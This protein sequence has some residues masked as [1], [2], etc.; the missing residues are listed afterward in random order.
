MIQGGRGGAR[1]D[2][3]LGAGNVLDGGDGDDTL[4]GGAQADTAFGGA[5]KDTILGMGGDDELFGQAD[6]DALD[7]GDGDDLLVVGAGG[8]SQGQTAIGGFGDD[9]IVVRDV[10]LGGEFAVAPTGQSADTYR[11]DGGMDTLV[12]DT[13][14]LLAADD[15]LLVSLSNAQ[16]N[17]YGV[18]TA[19]GIEVGIFAGGAGDNVFSAEVFTGRVVMRGNGG[20]DT[21]TGGD[22]DDLLD[23]GIDVDNQLAGGK[24]DD[25]FLVGVGSTTRI[26][27]FPNAG[28]DT[29]DLAPLG[30]AG[31][32]VRVGNAAEGVT[33]TSTTP[34]VTV[35][36]FND[37][38]DHVLL[39]NGTNSLTLRN[40]MTTTARFVAGGGSDSIRY[41]DTVG[42]WGAW[43]AGVTVDLAAGTATG[44]AGA[45]GFDHV[46]GGE[47]NDELS[48]NNDANR[49]DGRGGNDTLT[50]RRGDDTLFGGSGDDSLF[51]DADNDTL[52]GEGGMNELAG[53]TGDDA[54]EFLDFGQT[55]TVDEDFD[56]GTDRM[57]FSTGETRILFDVGGQIVA[58]FGTSRVTALSAAGIDLVR[59]GPAA[60][61]FRIADGAAFAGRLEGGGTTGDGFKYLDTLDYSLW[62]SPVSVDYSVVAAVGAPRAVTGVAGVVD[63]RHVIGGSRSDTLTGGADP[64]WFEGR[65]G[66]D[67]L[68]GSSLADKLEGDAGGDTIRGA[69][70]NDL[71]RGGVGNDTLE[72]GAD[73]DTF[74]FADAFGTDSVL[75]GPDGGSDVM[76]FSAVSV[77]LAVAIGS[78]TATT[79]AGDRAT[80]AGDAIERVVGGA[81]GD[82]FVITGPDVV[83]AGTLDGGAGVNELAY[84][85]PTRE[86]A[87][88][89]AAGDRPNVGGALRFATVTADS[90]LFAPVF[91][92][93]FTG[94]VNENAPLD[95]IVFTAAA[96]DA[97]DPPGNVITYALVAGLG[98][99]ADLVT[100]EPTSGKVR[101]KAPANFETQNAYFFRV[102]ATDAGVP[103][104]SATLDVRVNVL[105]VAEPATPPRIAAPA[106]FFFTEDTPGPLRFT[107]TPFSDADSPAATLMTVT[108][109]I[110]DGAIAAAN[111]GGVVV[112][113]PPTART[114]TGTLANLNAFFTADPARITYAP[115]AD[116]SG[117][118]VLGVTIAEGPVTQRLSSAV[119]VPVTIAAV[120]D[121]PTVR[122][123]LGFVVQED[124]PGNLRWPAGLPVVTD[125]DSPVVSVRLSVDAGQIVAANGL[126]V[127]V[128]GTPAAR[129]FTGT[130]AAV[131]A[132]FAALGRI[133]YAPAANDFGDRTLRIEAGDGVAAAA[134][135]RTIRVTPVNDAP[136]IAALAA[137]ADGRRNT[138]FEITHDMLLARSG[139]RDIDTAALAFRVESVV[140][141]SLQRWNGA[142]W[143]N[144]VV[145]N[146]TPAAQRLIGPGQR[147]RWVPP[148]GAVGAIA[149]FTIRAW[150]GQAASAVQ[151]RVTVN[152]L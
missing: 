65:D 19:L 66:G 10:T 151:S 114:F 79:A 8:G 111:G 48:G 83:F 122:A 12:L 102:L 21:L 52:R 15:L 69:A 24:G 92:S 56:Q 44:T 75:E 23:A 106:A 137:F 6:A 18:D 109:R 103:S 127:V 9:T 36:F 112:G 11:G 91:N 55:D 16:L 140:R 33:A 147:I 93:G 78:V 14:P 67:T 4:T 132:Y 101:L 64:V 86:I 148:A 142:R 1:S 43:A 115:A 81:A 34:G 25:R 104:R 54:Y 98:D 117:P 141:G 13:S 96:T 120:N 87:A 39:G 105:N 60:D 46:V 100:I 31:F 42:D 47:G 113:G 30:S 133:R 77:P 20:K 35:R 149:A 68:I 41:T 152:L 150:D 29:L 40:G 62:T 26:N 131:T 63:L 116:A 57:V 80:H 145:R 27:E 5:G 121:A 45:V 32:D 94:A 88:A 143:V 37:G 89:V 144:F 139:A 135:A 50:G 51:G 7:G 126:G 3:T 71:I 84:D 99:D 38:V 118:R 124:V 61:T 58:T 17:A 123:P 59:G 2:G 49:L 134:T 129:T 119:N 85:N 146:D 76:D 74:E 72:G 136:T 110:A 108:L 73:N 138:P 107:G 22:G 90:N 53:N 125:V 70:G 95:T 97:D 28:T 128:A 130:K 82:R